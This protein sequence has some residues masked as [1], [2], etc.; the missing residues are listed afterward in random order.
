M[1]RNNHCE[2]SEVIRKSEI[3]KIVN[4]PDSDLSSDESVKNLCF[5]DSSNSEVMEDMI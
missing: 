1:L 5:S 2:K 3:T 4:E